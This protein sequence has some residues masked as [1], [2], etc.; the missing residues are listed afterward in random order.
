MANVR[1]KVNRNGIR[2]LLRSDEVLADLEERGQR[3][4][5]AAGDGH[6]VESEVGQNRARVAVITDTIE[7]R[8][9]E[10]KNR[11]LTRAIDAGRG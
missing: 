5:A 2:D 8:I 10:A 1:I 9:S 7:A 3:I 11:T 6:R 4:A